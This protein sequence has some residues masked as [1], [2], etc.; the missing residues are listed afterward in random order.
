MVDPLF[1][2]GCG[3]FSG[4]FMLSSSRTTGLWTPEEGL[5]EDDGS[6]VGGATAIGGGSRRRI[7][8]GHCES[9]D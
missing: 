1:D 8:G 4:D 7:G 3:K 5:K 6:L 2:A 9:S